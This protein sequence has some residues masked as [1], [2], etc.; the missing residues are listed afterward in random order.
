MKM[1]PI[2]S[3]ET[4]AIKSQTPGNYPKRNK[5][6][7]HVY[8]YYSLGPFADSLAEYSLFCGIT[9][10]RLVNSYWRFEST[11][12]FETSVAICLFIWR[13]VL[14]YIFWIPE[15]S[16]T[17]IVRTQWWS[18]QH[19]ISVFI[20]TH[21][22]QCIAYKRPAL[23][24]GMLILYSFCVTFLCYHILLPVGVSGY[25]CASVILLILLPISYFSAYF[26]F[27]SYPTRCI[28]C[29]TLALVILFGAQWALRIRLG[30]A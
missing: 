17:F 29:Y 6:Q 30:I 26:V 16:L 15:T 10:R 23:T 24:V 9:P 28:Y 3:S 5:L 22:P 12:I 14:G 2:V 1:E 8:V 20:V 25:P 27:N 18:L 19:H 11:K 21:S 7:R 13:N 4:S